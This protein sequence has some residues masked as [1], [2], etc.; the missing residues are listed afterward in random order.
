MADHAAIC[1]GQ[2]E[3][4]PGDSPFYLRATF[5]VY[6]ENA[7]P[8]AEAIYLR[9]RPPVLTQAGITALQDEILK[10][11]ADNVGGSPMRAF[12]HGYGGIEM[13]AQEATDAGWRVLADHPK[14]TPTFGG[15]EA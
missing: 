7:M 15:S 6:W 10:L 9:N 11:L 3:L 8:S 4:L 14:P 1:P 13:T 2:K 5:T 12:Y